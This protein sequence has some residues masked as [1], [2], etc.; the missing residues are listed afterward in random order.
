MF[1]LTI[2]L[3][4]KLTVRG[5][6]GGPGARAMSRAGEGNGHVPDLVATLHQPME[7]KSVLVH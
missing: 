6:S 5:V 3:F 1:N 4:I 7:G 2:L